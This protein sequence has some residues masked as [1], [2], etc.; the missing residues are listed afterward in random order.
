MEDLVLLVEDDV[1][2][3]KVLKDF[4]EANDLP[5]IW[6]KDGDDA[7]KQFKEHF[8]RLVVLDVVLPDKDGFE[9]A[10]EI[11]KLNSVVPVLFMTGTA[12][13]DR[14]KIRAYRELKA[15]NY[16]EK[17]ILPYVALA[18]IQS[19]LY[20]PNQH[21]LVTK[22]YKITIRGQQLFINDKVFRMRE[23][24]AQVFSILLENMNRQV[25]RQE[26]IANCWHE[27]RHEH[28]QVNNALD[29][30]ISRI[31]KILEVFPDIEIKTI[32][33]GGYRLLIE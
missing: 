16:L 29:S 17:P 28:E 9:V 27:S 11:R 12:L 32:Y 7:V 3:G 19:L 20:P 1:D 31:R 10:F 4:L 14:N 2:F 6:S 13:D 8:P 15:V 30:T 26:I 25:A 21:K 33:A 22:D 23:K 24:D 5:V 18:Q